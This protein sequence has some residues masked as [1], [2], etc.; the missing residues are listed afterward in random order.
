MSSLGGGVVSVEAMSWFCG[1]EYPDTAGDTEELSL[2]F[3]GFRTSSGP[4]AFKFMFTSTEAAS[5][6]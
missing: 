3:I 2:S 6:S 5:K 1:S 4:G